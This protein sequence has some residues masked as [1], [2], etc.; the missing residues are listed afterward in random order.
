MNL[1]VAGTLQANFGRK[2][3]LD[4][5]H[6]D[7]G[8][9][10]F[11]AHTLRAE[12]FDASE[13][14]TGRGTPLVFAQNQRDEIRDLKN[15]AGAVAAEPGMKQQTF[16][17]LGFNWQAGG[18]KAMVGGTNDRSDAIHVGQ[19]PAVAYG[20]DPGQSSNPKT[21]DQITVNGSPPLPAGQGAAG[22]IAVAFQTRIARNGRGQPKDITD[23][24]TSCEGG[25]H[26]DSKPH[27]AGTFGVRRLTPRECERLQG[28]PDDWTRWDADGKEQ[29][30]SPRYRQM[31]NAV[32][33][34]PVKWIGER[35]ANA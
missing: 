27:V 3:G 10:M 35:I 32:S 13:D 11:I 1:A 33:V 31:G 23:A 2:Q 5:Q 22:R 18:S 4:N 19:V 26:A 6:V 28:F 34:P 8:C 24:L 30:D 17:A 20:F 15:L 7:N 16:V 25:T 29:A 14:G 12:G 21:T 9:P